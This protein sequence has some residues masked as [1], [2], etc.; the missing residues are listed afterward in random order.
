MKTAQPKRGRPPKKPSLLDDFDIDYEEPDVEEP[1]D[2]W[3]DGWDVEEADS[4]RKRGRP[5]KTKNPAKKSKN[6]TTIENL[7]DD[8]YW[9]SD[10]EV[11]ACNLAVQLG[12]RLLKEKVQLTP[13]DFGAIEDLLKQRGRSQSTAKPARA[14]K[15]PGKRPPKA[16]AP[17]R[18]VD[19]IRILDPGYVVDPEPVES[20]I[21]IETTNGVKK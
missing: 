5:P 3:G 13:E 7:V 18:T 10:A 12:K 19:T 21:E 17:S 1:D 11:E 4:P 8:L 2:G 15:S 20:N 9:M 14:R 16:Q 6:L